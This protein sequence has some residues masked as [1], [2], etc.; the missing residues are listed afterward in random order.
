MTL[1]AA[2]HSTL[3]EQT[4][5][6]AT[7]RKAT[8]V[9][10]L[11]SAVDQ[12]AAVVEGTVSKI[13]YEYTDADGPWTVITFS[14]VKARHG[15]SAQEISVRQFGGRLPNGQYIVASHLPV[16]VEGK[17]YIMFLRNTAWNM[18]PIVGDFALRLETV[19]G[20]EMLVNTDGKAV[21]G[22]ASGGIETSAPVFDVP[23]PDGAAPQAN[24]LGVADL[25]REPLDRSG[26]FKALDTNLKSLGIGVKGS[27]QSRPA[28]EFKWQA[29][30]LAPD[31]DAK[32]GKTPS[33]AGSGPEVDTTAPSR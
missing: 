4:P 6:G 28:G 19:N 16:F 2:T 8:A 3:A 26:F 7:L 29:Q 24:Q 32:P 20:K 10:D 18:S 15:K 1:P 25:E 17:R 14:D 30:R 33:K 27:V 11:R 21:V 22:F 23:V 13:D 5:P 12:T 31:A 9:T